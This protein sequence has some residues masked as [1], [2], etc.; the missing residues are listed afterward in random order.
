[1]L[2]A[3]RIAEDRRTFVDAVVDRVAAPQRD[4]TEL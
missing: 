4:S 3:G 1:M 2:K